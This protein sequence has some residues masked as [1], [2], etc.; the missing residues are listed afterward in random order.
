MIDGIS[1]EIEPELPEVLE[2]AIVI[3]EW[4]AVVVQGRRLHLPFPPTDI[5]L[6][7]S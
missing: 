2:T 4:K 5:V 6:V 3:V 7:G 1:I